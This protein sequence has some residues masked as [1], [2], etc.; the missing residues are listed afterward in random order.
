MLLIVRIKRTIDNNMP[1]EIT[2]A[3]L[4]GAFKLLAGRLD[5]AQ[6]EPVRLVVCGGSALIATGL[7]QRTTKDVD[8][9]AMIDSGQH[10]A[11]PDPLPAFL[12]EAARQVARDL[13]L[14]DNWLNNGPSRGEGG[15]YQM[16]LP[17]GF[18][19]RLTERSYGSQLTVYFIG[20]LDQIHFKL[21]AAADQRDG[22]HLTDLRAL[23]PKDGELEAAARWAMTH[24]VSDGFKMV[25]KE[26]LRELGHE[27]V[28]ENI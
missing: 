18:A 7:R 3:S 20:R 17:G 14:F 11:S 24:D 4:D 1:N 13:G 9:V 16:G 8:I 23:N 6:N 2:Y 19:G 10:L 22:T 12:L 21:Y 26:T 25:L 15:L 27:S 5:L 28:A